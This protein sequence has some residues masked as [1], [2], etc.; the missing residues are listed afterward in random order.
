MEGR[1]EEE[2][3]GDEEEKRRRLGRRRRRRRRGK[4]EELRTYKH[5]YS[6]VHLVSLTCGGCIALVRVWRGQETLKEEGRV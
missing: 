2:G 5:T 6:C 4:E 1:K 3:K